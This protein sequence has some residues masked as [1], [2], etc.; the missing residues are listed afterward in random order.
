MRVNCSR[1]QP[2]PARR[3]QP[4]VL[5]RLHISACSTTHMPLTTGLE[6]L[7]LS[8]FLSLSLSVFTLRCLTHPLSKVGVVHLAPGVGITDLSGCRD[9][10]RRRVACARNRGLNGRSTRGDFAEGDEKPRTPLRGR[11]EASA[12]TVATHNND[13]KNFFVS[14]PLGIQLLQSLL[15]GAA[16]ASPACAVK[17]HHQ[18]YAG[19]ERSLGAI[20][21]DE[22]AE[23]VG[24][25]W[26]AS[27]EVAAQRTSS[28]H[29]W[30]HSNR[31]R[32]L[33]RTRHQHG[34]GTVRDD[35]T[36]RG[37]RAGVPRCPWPHRPATRK[38]HEAKKAESARPSLIKSQSGVG[39]AG[40]D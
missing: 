27:W 34:P 19:V 20:R 28:V 14:V 33:P 17:H 23:K 15:E 30:S 6:S 24:H 11:R 18:F 9:D 16:R 2:G 25:R 1:L 7:S 8:L 13:L 40:D 4:P 22:R 12:I 26:P 21:C 10:T 32:A 39:E 36:P 3:P 5:V 29:G 37:S 38:S 35:A 31:L